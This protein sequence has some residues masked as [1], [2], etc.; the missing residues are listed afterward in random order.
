MRTTARL[1]RNIREVPAGN[2]PS[3]LTLPSTATLIQEGAARTTS[4]VL[5]PEV[6]A[7]DGEAPGDAEA[8]GE[9]DESGDGEA[10]GE[11]E[12]AG[13]GE[14][15]ALGETEALLEGRAATAPG[16]DRPVNSV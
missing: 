10:P 3:M 16:F 7:G 11:A 1:P 12:A 13:D 14:A 9:A 4:I 8:P 15:G 6:T 5:G 2:V